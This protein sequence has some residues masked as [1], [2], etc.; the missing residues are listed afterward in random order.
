MEDCEVMIFIIDHY[1]PKMSNRSTLLRYLRKEMGRS[2]SEERFQAIF[3]RYLRE[4]A[5]STH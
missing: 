3:N 5:P 1:G 2:C 4:Y